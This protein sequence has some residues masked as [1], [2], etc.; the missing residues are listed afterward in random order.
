MKEDVEQRVLELTG[1]LCDENITPEQF[2]ELDGLLSG[3][4]EARELYRSFL[5]LHRKLE[6]G[7]LKAQAATA[8]VIPF[9]RRSR[10]LLSA[11]AVLFALLFLGSLL[12]RSPFGNG[13][14]V[15]IPEEPPIAV[16]TRAI[17][18]EWQHKTRFQAVLGEALE[19]D[20]L[21]LKSGILEITFGSGATVSLEG[22]AR[23]RVDSAMHC[24]SK[25]GRLTA[26]C[27]ESAYG[28]TI[29]FP[30]GKVVDKGTE[31]ALNTEPEGKT[32][33]HVFDGEVVVA[34][35]DGE[36][37]VINEERLLERSSV[38]LGPDRKIEKISYDDQ[39]FA[40]LKRKNLIQ[41][42]PIKL[43][44]DLGH[45]AGTY[46]GTNSP[47]HA[48][49]DL[50]AHENVWTQIVGDQSGTFVLADGNLCPHPIRVDYGHGDGVVDWD[51]DPVDPWGQVYSR[52]KGVF[53][54]ALCQDHRPWDYDLGLR[55]SGLPAGS[56]RVY[57]LCRSVRR[58][59]ASYDVSFGV[60]LDRQLPQPIEMP[61]MDPEIVPE[62]KK[63][64]T[65]EVEEVEV[66]GPDDWVT[67][68]TRYSRE[69]SIR[70]TP[71]HGRSVLLGLQIVEV[72]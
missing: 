64:V 20:W 44:F 41:S 66:S 15:S 33:V 22:P 45:R 60:N 16:L 53:N 17:D 13:E 23:L 63:G 6:D 69:R 39:S 19:P 61:P 34:K 36:E 58:P 70:E 26:N 1:L 62:W 14:V 29:R 37:R 56:Y 59:G 68:I 51:V 48:A 49:G 18:V 4:P 72:E 27:P 65:Y 9:P 54:T 52:A 57:A 5:G 11:A 31:F 24:V 28:F 30:G 71:H 47:A 40:G 38:S 55:V 42:Q 46:N 25:Y 50:H 7:A 32:E 10:M 3:D 2:A 8:E 35:T 43:Q 21:R 12:L 67:F